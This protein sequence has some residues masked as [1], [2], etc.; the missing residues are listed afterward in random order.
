[1]LGLE[2]GSPTQVEPWSIIT[3]PKHW[4]WEGR[5]QRKCAGAKSTV[6][7][8]PLPLPLAALPRTVKTGQGKQVS[9]NVASQVSDLELV[10]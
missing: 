1:M 4:I 7:T 2:I 6:E 5:Y 8:T 9:F 10:T 3:R